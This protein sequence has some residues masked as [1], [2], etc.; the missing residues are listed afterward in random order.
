MSQKLTLEQKV[1]RILFYLES[2]QT[3]KHVG[4]VEQVDINTDDI[5][6]FKTDRKV[7]IGKIGVI[8]IILGAI[9]G[10]LMKLFFR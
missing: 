6:Q 7:L 10:F 9:G 3:T 4:L 2:D 5:N 1:D 8:S